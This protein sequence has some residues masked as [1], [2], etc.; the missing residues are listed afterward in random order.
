M[1][2]IQETLEAGNLAKEI[3]EFRPQNIVYSEFK[4]A[5][6]KYAVTSYE[7]VRYLSE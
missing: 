2:F 5:L 7:R 1:K 6:K 4:A 3:E